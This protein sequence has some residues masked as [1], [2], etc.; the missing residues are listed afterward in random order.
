[1]I[2]RPSAGGPVFLISVS[3][4][5]LHHGGEAANALDNA[6]MICGCLA[7][8]FAIEFEFESQPKNQ[9]HSRKSKAF[10]TRPP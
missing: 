6:A 9:N 1:V 5:R 10:A 7:L 3:H 4:N 8:A 2:G